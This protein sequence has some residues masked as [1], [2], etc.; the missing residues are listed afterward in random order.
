MNWGKWIFVSF[1]LFGILIFSLVAISM[2]Q[3]IDLVSQDYYEQEIN[4]QDKI[5]KMRNVENLEKKPKI[6]VVDKILSIEFDQNTENQFENGKVMLFSPLSQKE[7]KIFLI[8]KDNFPAYSMNLTE[9]RS[10]SWIV[11]L[12]WKE[13]TMEY[14][15]ESEI[16]L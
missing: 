15:I 8:E 10:G 9:F 16:E 3:E 6:E 12:E 4:Y 2:N 5:N 1:I 13:G 11:K 7:D 14:Y